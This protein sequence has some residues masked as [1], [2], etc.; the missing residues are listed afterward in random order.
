MK[1]IKYL[2]GLF[3]LWLFFSTITVLCL[4]RFALTYGEVKVTVDYTTN[5][6]EDITLYWDDGKGYTL[7][8]HISQTT[9][10]G[11]HTYNYTIRHNDSIAAVRI[12]PADD[13]DTV[14]LHSVS[15]NGIT[16]PVS[17]SDFSKCEHYNSHLKQEN[18]GVKIYRDKGCIDPYLIIPVPLSC[19][20]VLA[21]WKPSEIAWIIIILILDLVILIICIK[22]KFLKGFFI[23]HNLT[24]ILFIYVFLFLISAY[25]INRAV[26]FY[27]QQPNIENRRLIRFP[28]W[29]VLPA[30]PDSFFTATTQ[31]CS[32]YFNYRNI[33]VGTRSAL[34]IKLFKESPIPGIVLIGR[35]SMFFPAYTPL[36][37][38]YLGFMRYT[39]KQL[40]DIKTISK[41]KQ[42][43]LAKNGIQFY[44]TMIPAKQT[45]YYDLMPDYYRF[46][47]WKST[48]LDQVTAHMNNSGVNFISLQ[49]T[50]LNLRQRNP[51]KQLFYSYDTHWNEY[52]A[53]KCYQ[54]V[55]NAIYKNDSSFGK[56]LR[57]E[58]V[59]IDTLE[60]NQ[61]DLAKC[62][63]VNEIYKRPLYKIHPV[64]RDKVSIQKIIHSD[65]SATLIYTNPK[66]HG[67]AV[68]FRDSYMIQWVPFFSH[69]FK[70][71]ILIYSHSMNLQEIM[72]YKPDVVVDEI[73]ELFIDHLLLPLQSVPY[74]AP[75]KN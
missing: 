30:K 31:W 60:D 65:R 51:D 6:A 18:G 71:C 34:Y 3:V 72:Y 57:D 67:R 62:L 12:D 35:K 75:E 28:E 73:G 11:R 38:D 15:V 48:L 21:V 27:P 40:N 22:R 32:D 25:W 50:L 41:E 45:V 29:K 54:G 36:L 42:D 66:G 59:V 20:A 55:M 61:G 23:K 4:L 58:D 63:L 7:D 19:R 47:Q 33:L 56:P 16:C 43:V 1:Q 49:D 69:H 53:F 14:I 64:I 46:R 52:G 26:D 68:F 74:H 39:D 70:E 24:Q 10:T 8:N 13:C 17:C 2:V 37:F 9:R 5:K 44:I